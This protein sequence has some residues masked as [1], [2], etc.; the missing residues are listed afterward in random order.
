MRT[1]QNY[2]RGERP[3]SKDLLLSLLNNFKADPAW[4]LTGVGSG[5]EITGAPAQQIDLNLFAILSVNFQEER[6]KA[7]LRDRDPYGYYYFLGEL[8]NRVLSCVPSYEDL[9]QGGGRVRDKLME[10]IKIAVRREKMTQSLE[11]DLANSRN[12]IFDDELTDSE[13][14]ISSQATDGDKV[15]ISQEIAGKKHQIAGHNLINEAPQKKRKK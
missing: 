13:H 8:Y 7:G 10:E 14:S 12:H 5:T 15:S 4:V 11:D 6:K 1:Y 3:I 2:E 9:L